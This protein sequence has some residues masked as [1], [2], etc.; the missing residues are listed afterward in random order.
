[1]VGGPGDDWVIVRQSSGGRGRSKRKA[2]VVHIISHRGR[3]TRNER[4]PVHKEQNR[5][6][7]V[8]ERC[9]WKPSGRP[10]EAHPTGG[11]YRTR[12]RVG[13]STVVLGHAAHGYS[14]AFE[15]PPNRRPTT[16]KRIVCEPSGQPCW[17]HVTHG[18]VQRGYRAGFQSPD[19]PLA[20]ISRPDAGAESFNVSP[21]MTARWKRAVT[22]NQRK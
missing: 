9:S 5:N 8:T 10:I 4:S 6:K 11:R 21:L 14:R 17:H 20:W 18:R 19:R 7:F 16:W 12:Y 13:E 1:M 22:F 15:A 2:I 3:H